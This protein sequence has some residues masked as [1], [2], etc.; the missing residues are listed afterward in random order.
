MVIF[1]VF[2]RFQVLNTAC[3]R[4][5]LTISVPS[6]CEKR[7]ASESSAGVKKKYSREFFMYFAP[8]RPPEGSVLLKGDSI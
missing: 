7:L 8:S 6:S 1:W 5:A 3:L 2:M 4:Q